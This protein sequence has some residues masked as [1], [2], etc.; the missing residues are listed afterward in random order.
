EPDLGAPP[1]R[2]QERGGHDVLGDG[3][4]GRSPEAVVVDGAGVALE[5]VAERVRPAAHRPAPQTDVGGA[6]RIPRRGHRPVHLGNGARV[7]GRTTRQDPAASRYTSTIRRSFA[8][9]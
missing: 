9:I 2:V 7:P 6:K 5:Q 3:P 1:P 8:A 4:V